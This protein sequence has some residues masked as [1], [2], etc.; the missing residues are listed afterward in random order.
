MAI[1]YTDGNSRFFYVVERYTV[2]QQDWIKYKNTTGE[3]FTCLKEAF[4]AR[5]TPM[6]QE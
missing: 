2:G 6:E 3:E 4:D 1:V 5:F